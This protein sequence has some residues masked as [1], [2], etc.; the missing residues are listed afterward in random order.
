ML[1]SLP[2]EGGNMKKLMMIGL[3]LV[4]FV[5][6]GWVTPK[7]SEA[8]DPLTL[9][10]F[11]ITIGLIGGSLFNYNQ[12]PECRKEESMGAMGECIKKAQQEREKKEGI[13]DD[14]QK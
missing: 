6:W 4:L 10:G 2:F 3:V 13:R 1:I 8:I 11:S 5:S 14:I 12:Y 9:F 7:K